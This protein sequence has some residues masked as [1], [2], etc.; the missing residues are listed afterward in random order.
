MGAM[1]MVVPWKY[2]PL[3]GHKELEVMAVSTDEKT[4]S[5][6]TLFSDLSFLQSRN[7]CSVVKGS[8]VMAHLS[9]SLHTSRPTRATRTFRAL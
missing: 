7:S 5:F 1:P 9:A 8:C 6:S 3:L 4:I 2:T